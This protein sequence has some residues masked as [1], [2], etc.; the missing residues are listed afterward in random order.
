MQGTILGLLIYE[1]NAVTTSSAIRATLLPYQ[2]MGTD[3][4]TIV[5][6]PKD[7]CPASTDDGCC[8]LC[9][10]PQFCGCGCGEC[11]AAIHKQRFIIS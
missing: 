11:P 7:Y 3:G 1:S 4:Y 9:G 5:N 6:M 10:M 2:L 8:R